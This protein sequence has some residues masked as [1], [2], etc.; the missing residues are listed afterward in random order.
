MFKAGIELNTKENDPFGAKTEADA[1]ANL[2]NKQ[3]YSKVPEVL[4]WRKYSVA[5]GVYHSVTTLLASGVVDSDGAAGLSQSL[6]D[7]YLNAD[8]TFINPN[9]VKFKDFNETFKNRD[10]RLTETVMST[11]HKFR[12][13]T[14]TRPMCVKEYQT[15]ESDEIKKSN[16]EIL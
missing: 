5:E 1:F 6:V 10:P 11:G 7:N 2:F 8:G 15:G 13:A 16:S 9:D 3:D 12:S 4:F 14:V